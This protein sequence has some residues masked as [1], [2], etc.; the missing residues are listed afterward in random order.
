[1]KVLLKSSRD[2]HVYLAVVKENTH[3]LEVCLLINR[4]FQLT[5]LP[6]AIAILCFFFFLF[7]SLALYRYLSIT[8]IPFIFPVSIAPGYLGN[9]LL[10]FHRKQIERGKGSIAAK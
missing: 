10:Y 9:Q 3:Q 4:Y 6:L 2:S 7:L 8:L 1:M 5:F